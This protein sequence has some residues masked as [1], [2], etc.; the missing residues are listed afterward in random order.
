MNSISYKLVMIACVAILA[1]S[2][3]GCS[4]RGGTG[5]QD[6]TPTVLDIDGDDTPNIDDK[7]MDGDG[8]DNDVDNDID[9]DDITDDI[10]SDIDNDDVD[11]GDDIDIDGDGIVNDEDP[12]IDN[13]GIPNEDDDTPGGTGSDIDGT[14]GDS[15][16]GDDVNGGDNGD[17]DYTSGIGVTALDTVVYSIY[18]DADQGKGTVSADDVI[19]L[20]DVRQE[21]A[22]NDIPLSTFSITDLSVSIGDENAFISANRDVRVVVRFSYLDGDGNQALVLQSAATEGLAGPVLTLGDLAD[23]VA[24]N[25][26]IFG[27]PGFNGF[28]ELIKNESVPELP[29]LIEVE[30]LDDPAGGGE[31]ELDFVIKVAGKKPF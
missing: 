14:E 19:D 7:D 20:D 2:F 23:S 27:G 10:D 30:F 3:A 11:I 25:K 4:K 16:T 29:S 9:G 22:D 13:D 26:E 17:D 15:N 12:D 1:A 5:P 28:T 21:I 18:V 6:N 24:L 8:L 31:L